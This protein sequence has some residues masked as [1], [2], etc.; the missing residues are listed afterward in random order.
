MRTITLAVPKFGFVVGTRA[1]LG[2][3]IG[4]LAATRLSAE[5]S[6]STLS[7]SP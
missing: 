5:R 3:G 6:N 4:L 1:M 7:G 2:A